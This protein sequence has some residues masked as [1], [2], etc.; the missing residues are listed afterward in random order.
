MLKVGLV[1]LVVQLWL[2]PLAPRY[3]AVARAANFQMAF[4]EVVVPGFASEVKYSRSALPAVL[5]TPAAPLFS[6]K[7]G[8]QL[9][10]V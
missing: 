5:A 2:P 4:I 10:A 3:T 9:L 6:E 8:E 7:T 1:R